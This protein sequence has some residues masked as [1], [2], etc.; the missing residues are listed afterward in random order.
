MS[1][2]QSP[3]LRDVVRRCFFATHIGRSTDDVVIDDD[4]NAAFIAA[5]LREIP[6]ASVFDL[7]WQLYNLRKQPPGIG[8]VATVKRHDNH[9]DYIHAS[10]IAAR[11]ME[12]RHGLTIDQVLCDP[13]MRREFD[14]VAQAIVPGVSVY[15]L[16]K[17]ALKLRKNRQL[18]PELMKRVAD[19]GTT[20]RMYPAE[21][22]RKKPDL[23][24]RLPGI[25][26]F[27]DRTGYLYIGEAGNL[28]GRVEKHLDH[29][30]RKAV[31]RYLWEHRYTDLII[32]M[33]V[34]RKDSEGNKSKPRKAYEAD[35]IRSRKP[36]LNIQAKLHGV[37]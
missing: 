11:H 30:D 10:E 29:S 23:I 2:A 19:W 16:R 12:D 31:A 18:R 15:L 5:C 28:R 9:D 13:H 37:H 3:N 7:N 14:A 25:Y 20:V 34:F 24:P 32:E 1:D 27:R 6:S 21:E 8:K 22:L 33:H 4:L 17:A 35:L 26:I 36:R